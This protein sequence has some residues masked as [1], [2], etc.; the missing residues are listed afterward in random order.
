MSEFT[1]YL[2]LGSNVGDRR[3]TIESAIDHL[4]AAD[5]LRVVR[6]SPLIETTPGD[7][8]DLVSIR[9]R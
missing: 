3:A 9:F 7:E 6:V 8:V 1:A 4:A 5:G 2:G